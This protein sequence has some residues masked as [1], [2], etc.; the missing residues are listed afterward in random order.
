[1]RPA[2]QVRRDLIRQWIT[3]A[4]EDLG[5]AE[6]LILHNTSYLSAV[7]FH[8]QQAAEKFLKALLTFNQIE[9]PKTHDLGALLDLVSPVDT[10]LAESLNDIL[11]LNPYGVEIRYPGDMPAIDPE[12]AQKA[13]ELA[14]KVRDAVVKLLPPDIL[15]RSAHPQ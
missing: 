9:F 13:L 14:K 6:I 11:L 10:S 12:D 8:C 5:A 2:D 15:P 4:E 3:T 1:M 7:G